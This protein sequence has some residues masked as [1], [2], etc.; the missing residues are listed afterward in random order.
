MKHGYGV[1]K[2]MMRWCLFVKRMR[3]LNEGL[4]CIIGCSSWWCELWLYTGNLDQ[5]YI[6]SMSLYCKMDFKLMLLLLL[7]PLLQ[8]QYTSSIQYGISD[9][10]YVCMWACD[11]CDTCIP[12]TL[13]RML[14]P[15]LTNAHMYMTNWW[16]LVKG[17][18]K[19]KKT[20][21]GSAGNQRQKL[22]QRAWK[23]R[24]VYR[25]LLLGHYYHRAICVASKKQENTFKDWI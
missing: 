22:S 9:T 10:V 1:L 11:H 4:C 14:G 12:Q 19:E 7:L 21:F 17:Y 13:M 5:S 3:D 8:D 15:E 24:N 2:G 20:L 18:E 6:S 25:H 23:H 16:M